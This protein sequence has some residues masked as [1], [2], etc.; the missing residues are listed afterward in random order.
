MFIKFHHEIDAVDDISEAN[1]FSRVGLVCNA[2]V[3]LCKIF[4]LSFKNG[5]NARNSKNFTLKITF[6]WKLEVQISEKRK[7][8]R[9][10]KEK[11]KRGRQKEKKKGKKF[12]L[13]HVDQI[14]WLH[15]E[16]S[17][18]EARTTCER[19][20]KKKFV[21]LP[22]TQRPTLVFSSFFH[23][24][25]PNSQFLSVW[26]ENPPTP[27]FENRLPHTQAWPKPSENKGFLIFFRFSTV[28]TSATS[29]V[30]Y[31]PDVVCIHADI[32]RFNIFCH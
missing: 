26:G 10:M 31:A 30:N 18:R 3:R 16:P 8:E 7:K 23:N 12:I 21:T 17:E 6:F 20:V 22:K 9:K 24:F 28:A 5:K 2:C 32:F 1:K 19:P 4:W 27:R 15:S 25:P 14:V 11:E 29:A 13:S